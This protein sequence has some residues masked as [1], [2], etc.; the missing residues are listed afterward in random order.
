MKMNDLTFIMISTHRAPDGSAVTIRISAI[1]ETPR[2][3]WDENGSWAGQPAPVLSIP[4]PCHMN[5]LTPAPL[6]EKGEGVKVG[7]V[8]ARFIAPCGVTR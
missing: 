8:G 6:L 3:S 1:G 5:D 2:R 7:N 4:H